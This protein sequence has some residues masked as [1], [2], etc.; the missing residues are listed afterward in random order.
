MTAKIID[1]KAIAKKLRAE[2]HSR[3]DQLRSRHSLTP[4]LAVILV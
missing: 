2:Y 4:A 3:V 1:G